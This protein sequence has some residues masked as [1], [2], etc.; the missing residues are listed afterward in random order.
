MHGQI[1][2]VFCFGKHKPGEICFSDAG[3]SGDHFYFTAAIRDIAVQILFG[4]KIEQIILTYGNLSENRNI[5]R[6]AA[7]A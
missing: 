4:Q 2:M 5:F 7:L 3:A 1:T 6:D